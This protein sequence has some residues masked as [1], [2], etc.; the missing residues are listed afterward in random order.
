MVSQAGVRQTIVAHSLLTTE[1]VLSRCCVY[2]SG[3]P[4]D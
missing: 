4:E 2:V 3:R 1:A